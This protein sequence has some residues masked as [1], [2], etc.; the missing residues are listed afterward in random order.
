MSRVSCEVA[1]HHF[2]L[3]DELLATPVSY[4]TNMKMNPPLRAAS[5]RDEML[6]GIVDGSVDAIATDHAPAS[7][8]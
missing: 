2:T 1:P 3:T 8:R 7:L 5:D 4:D 6:K